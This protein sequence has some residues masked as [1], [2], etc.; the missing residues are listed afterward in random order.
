MTCR[1][2]LP[3]RR[4]AGVGQTWPSGLHLGRDQALEV[5]HDA[6]N[7]FRRSRRLNTARVGAPHGG[8]GTGS[9]R[10]GGRARAEGDRK[11]AGVR[12]VPYHPWKLRRRLAAEDWR[13]WSGIAAAQGSVGGGVTSGRAAAQRRT[14]R[15]RPGVWRRIR[16]GGVRDGCG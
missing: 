6:V 4:L 16:E 12:R 14:A 11:G 10:Q 15:G 2:S 5:E 13:C 3:W 9:R 7:S 1:R 8:G